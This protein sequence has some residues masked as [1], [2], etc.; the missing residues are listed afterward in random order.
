MPVDFCVWLLIGT[1][2]F[3]RVAGYCLAGGRQGRY[4]SVADIDSSLASSH[5]PPTFLLN[6]D[7]TQDVMTMTVGWH[8]CLQCWVAAP[9]PTTAATHPSGGGLA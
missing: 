3:Y 8:E 6:F 7:R 4:C 5:P 1:G 9:V 2:L